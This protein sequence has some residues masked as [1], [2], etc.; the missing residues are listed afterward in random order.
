MEKIKIEFNN[1]L[2]LKGMILAHEMDMK[3][4]DLVVLAIKKYIEEKENERPCS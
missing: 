2:L 4:N 3:F 1:E